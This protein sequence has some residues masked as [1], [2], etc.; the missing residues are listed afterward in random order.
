MQVEYKVEYIDIF[1]R[2]HKCETSISGEDM[3]EQDVIDWFGLDGKEVLWYKI[4][5]QQV[6]YYRVIWNEVAVMCP[7]FF[8]MCSCAGHQE[9]DPN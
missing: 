9:I 5:K 3:T 2:G 4:T 7:R 1:S 8:C 6:V